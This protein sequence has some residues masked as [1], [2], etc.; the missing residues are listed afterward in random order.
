MTRAITFS[1]ILSGIAL[2]ALLSIC[3]AILQRTGVDQLTS[4]AI[5]CGIYAFY[6]LDPYFRVKYRDRI[7]LEE[8]L[9]TALQKVLASHEF[10]EQR[11]NSA[12]RENAK[13]VIKLCDQKESHEQEL[14]R[15]KGAQ[16][17]LTEQYERMS[18]ELI[19]KT[20]AYNTQAAAVRAHE[21]RIFAL[22]KDLAAAKVAHEQAQDSVERL[23]QAAV[24][25]HEQLAAANKKAEDLQAQIDRSA[26]NSANARKRW[27]K[28]QDVEP[29]KE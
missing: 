24:R 22:N 8:E 15:I 6:V 18:T 25:A 12:E 1:Q 3:A 13:L 21:Q 9:T 23:Q 7:K 2:I 28:A 14:K 4:Y 26:K 11:A 16:A 19:E 29:I 20:R 27:E 5:V 17:Q 10:A